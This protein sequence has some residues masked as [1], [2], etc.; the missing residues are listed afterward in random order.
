MNV[1]DFVN[2]ATRAST[3]TAM[4]AAIGNIGSV[5]AAETCGQ[6]MSMTAL[7]I[8]EALAATA[9]SHA[10]TAVFGSAGYVDS[11]ASKPARVQL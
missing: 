7:L 3:T 6:L 2:C 11:T 4:A 1:C 10:A 9:S 8:S 5:K